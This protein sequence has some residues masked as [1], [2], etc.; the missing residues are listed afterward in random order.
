MGFSDRQCRALKSKLHKRH[1]R[2]RTAQGNSLNYIAGWHA[3]S[4]ANRIFGYDAW[5]RE[6]LSP[7]KVW[8][9]R[10]QGQFHCLYSCKVRI[11]VRAGP[12]VI[13]REGQGC[14]SGRSLSEDGAIEMGIK[15]A[16]T[17]ATKR[18]LATFGN[19][20]GLALYQG[21]GPAKQS[22]KL[23]VEAGRT[24]EFDSAEAMAAAMVKHVASLSSLRDVYAFWERNM[25]GLVALN[26][27]SRGEN[28][29]PQILQT[30]KSRGREVSALPGQSIP[31]QS[32]S[33][34]SMPGQSEPEIEADTN[35]QLAFPKER[36]LRDKLHLKWV[37][38]HPC[39]ICGRS[40][41]HAHHLKFAQPRAMGLKVSDDLT[42]PLCAG[43]HDALHRTGDEP[44]WWARHGIEPKKMAER[45]WRATDKSEGAE[46]EPLIACRKRE[47]S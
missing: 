23:I 20:F 1:V 4:E 27:D 32:T 7:T 13:V 47:E 10:R 30:L 45:L 11:S 15:A 28:L 34:Q 18:A 14:G 31:G 6:T 16:E 37:A 33:G 46:L 39:L 25:P 35:A 12:V 38:R 3:I 8:S 44:A 41:A 21:S 24:L 42:V 36:R 19:P 29:V 17:D 22:F 26:G 40:P 43:H 5:D 2:S 9:D